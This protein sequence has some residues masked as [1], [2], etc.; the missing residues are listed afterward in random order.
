MNGQHTACKNY[1]Q[2]NRFQI[3]TL[4]KMVIHNQNLIKQLELE[5]NLTLSNRS[6]TFIYRHKTTTAFASLIWP[7]NKMGTV[8]NTTK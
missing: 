8:T 2:Y 3:D 6:N 5:Q 7:P 1:L 4:K